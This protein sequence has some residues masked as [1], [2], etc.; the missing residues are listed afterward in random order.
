MTEFFACTAFAMTCDQSRDIV[1]QALLYSPQDETLRIAWQAL[2]DCSDQPTT[3]TANP[4]TLQ[5][6]YALG[7]DTNANYAS[8]AVSFLL[9]NDVGG[10][11][12][13][14]QMKPISS[15]FQQL[16]L[17]YAHESSQYAT[18]A[19]LHLKQSEATEV[20]TENA[21]GVDYYLPGHGGVLLAGVNWAELSRFSLRQARLAWRQQLASSWYLTPELKTRRYLG[22]AVLD[23]NLFMLSLAWQQANQPWV[24][25]LS[26][27]QDL[28]TGERA[29]GAYWLTEFKA[30]WRQKIG[31]HTLFV[32]AL[33]RR[34][35]DEQGYSELLDN[36]SRRDLLLTGMGL[37]WQLPAYSAVVPFVQ[38]DTF[39]QNSN[40]PLFEW[41]SN[42]IRIG[43]DVLW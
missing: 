23:G 39:Q 24:V 22:D 19:Y 37:Y 40:L 17:A 38:V 42:S 13:P 4:A 30:A 5:L 12:I 16:N 32:F 29:G 3:V 28:P 27:G 26:V 1:E 34:Q 20:S 43:V 31:L 9:T 15:F 2:R 41:Q 18:N 25:S 14:N 7:Y 36:N 21:G 6:S 35:Q 11:L 10:V 33:A 8:R